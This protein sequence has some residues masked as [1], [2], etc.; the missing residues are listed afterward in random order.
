MFVKICGLVSSY[1]VECVNI[2]TAEYAGF[3]FAPSR[4]QVGV[5]TART[6]RRELAG[7]IRAVGVVTDDVP[8]AAYGGIVDTVDVVQVY[9]NDCV[10]NIGGANVEVWRAYRATDA[11][12][13]GGLDSAAYG[14]ILIDS[15][16]PGG[17][18]TFD[19]RLL[20]GLPRGLP[21]ILAGGLNPDNVGGILRSLGEFNVIGV[22]VSS[23]VETNGA[24]DLEKMRRFVDCVKSV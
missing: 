15:S 20:D 3:V 23:G 13:S 16:E 2:C 5:D 8:A 17:G 18:K 11:D 21:F 1:D 10:V 22:D 14:K 4:R 24:K 6:L 7:G 19:L 12:V 9:S